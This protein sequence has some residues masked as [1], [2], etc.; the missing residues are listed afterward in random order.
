MVD[1]AKKGQTFD[2]LIAMN[3]T[4]GN[5]LVQTF[6]DSL[7]NETRTTEEIIHQLNL[8]G[9]ALEGSDSL[10]NPSSVFE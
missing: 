3:N 4:K 2:V 1:A 5:Q 7:V 9:I 6:V 8:Q 10:D